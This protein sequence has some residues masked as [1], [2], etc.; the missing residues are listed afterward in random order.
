MLTN[1]KFAAEDAMP[2]SSL[3]AKGHCCKNSCIHCPYG[4]T[5][6]KFGLKFWQ[7][8]DDNL[9]IAEKIAGKKMFFE[10]Y[11]LKDFH[12]VTL[13]DFYCALIRVDKLFV[14][15]FYLLD[16]FKEQGLSKEVVESY[17]FY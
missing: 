17:F 6:K 8:C 12:L 14:R 4:F 10:G 2:S 9:E 5:L 3:K 1:L 15:E 16:D 13:K 7:L 11:S